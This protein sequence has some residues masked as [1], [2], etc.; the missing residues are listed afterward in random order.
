MPFQIIFNKEHCVIEAQMQGEFDWAVMEKMIPEM[1]RT[2]R[3]NQCQRVLMDF[4]GAQYNV[5]TF[6]IYLTP[7]K[8][9]NEF[10]KYDI[11]IRRLRRALLFVKNAE[12][13]RFFETV[14]V[15]QSQAVR[16]FLD[17]KAARDWL[18][19]E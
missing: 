3:E 12:N 15:N 10:Q 5:S 18:L 7:E 1:A 19:E 14:S 2:I 4:R 11:D 13:F 8:L 9:F 16:I 6:T 17:E